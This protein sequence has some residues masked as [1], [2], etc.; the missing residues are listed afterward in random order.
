MDG[1]QLPLDR[2]TATH[3]GDVSSC[4]SLAL[5]RVVM[6]VH[7]PMLSFMLTQ[8]IDMT[9]MANYVVVTVLEV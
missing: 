6:L 9:N 1:G 5:G 7:A 3:D 4:F 2:T 8:K